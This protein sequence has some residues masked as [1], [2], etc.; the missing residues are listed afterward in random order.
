MANWHEA[1][2]PRGKRWTASRVYRALLAP[3]RWLDVHVF[4]SWQCARCGCT[5]RFACPEGCRWSVSWGG[6]QAV[7]TRCTTDEEAAWHKIVDETL[8]GRIERACSSDLIDPSTVSSRG[9]SRSTRHTS[10]GSAQRGL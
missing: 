2:P 8:R 1:S 4:N 9:V 10:A 7:C 5:E 6:Q 3:L